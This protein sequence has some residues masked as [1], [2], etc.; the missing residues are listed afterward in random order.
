M[1]SIA[2]VVAVWKRRALAEVVLRHISGMLMPQDRL[3]V[4]GSPED[5][6]WEDIVPGPA[7]LVVAPN[8]PLGAK[9][10][11]GISY[12]RHTGC[13]A[14]MCLGSDDLATP[15]YVL[16]ARVLM[17]GDVDVVGLLGCTQWRSADDLCVDVAGYMPEHPRHGEPVGSGRTFSR[18]L[19]ERINWHLFCPVQKYLDANLWEKL[20]PNAVKVIGTQADLGA[21]LDVKVGD[22]DMG[23]IMSGNGVSPSSIDALGLPPE[24]VAELREKFPPKEKWAGAR[25]AIINERSDDHFPPG[26]LRP[27]MRVLDLYCAGFLGMNT[28]SFCAD[29]G[30]KDYQGVDTDDGMLEKMRKAYPLA[31]RFVRSDAAVAV[32][33]H[34]EAGSLYDLVIVDPWTDWIADAWTRLDDFKKLLAPGGILLLGAL[35]AEKDAHPEML[36]HWRGDYVGGVWW[37]VIGA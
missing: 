37:A 14:V 35:N 9:W 22:S 16:N 18:R 27:E 12:A 17:D 20:P 33:L 36:F 3:I 4:V 32:S 31:W 29:A 28:A 19:L 13:D 8:E 34:I 21:L 10:Q 2:F 5:E 24:L 15:R 1:S 30:V 23:E 26:L 25:A 11:A 7:T 6:G